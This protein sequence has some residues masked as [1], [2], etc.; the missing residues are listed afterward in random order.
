MF[1]LSLLSLKAH[2]YVFQSF[3]KILR[4]FYTLW[5]LQ[6]FTTLVKNKLFLTYSSY[7]GITLK[8]QILRHCW[9]SR[10]VGKSF[11]FFR[12][13]EALFGFEN[14]MP[15]PAQQLA[16]STYSRRL[17]VYRTITMKSEQP[18][19]PV[20]YLCCWHPSGTVGLPGL[21]VKVYIFSL[22]ARHCLASKTSCCIHPS[23]QRVVL[24]PAVCQ[25]TGQLQYSLSS[26]FNQFTINVEQ[27][28]CWA[29]RTFGKSFHFFRVCEARILVQFTTLVK[30]K[31]FLTYFSHFG[32]TLKWW[33]LY[34]CSV[35]TKLF[36][37][38]LSHFGS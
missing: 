32:I 5:I 23:S 29:S 1:L 28:H 21:S 34:T 20:Y 22:S 37:T 30:N 7:F 11:H 36:F 17:P 2:T 38:N 13:C 33:I 26:H 31:L 18:L 19:Q 14:F 9:A 27:R 8:R 3:W 25:F 4:T 35:K 10:T 16:S 12:V 6:Q 24:T 15:F